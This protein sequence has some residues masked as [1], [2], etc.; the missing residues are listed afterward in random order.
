MDKIFGLPAHPL[1]VHLPVVLV[2]LVA[3]GAILLAVKKS[4]RGRFGRVLVVASFVSC[5]A[6]VLAKQSGEALFVR[7]NQA[8]DIARHQNFADTTLILAL[9]L[10]VAIV[11]MAVMHHRD[12]N[13]KTSKV[14]LIMSVASIAFGV[15]AM[16][17]TI[18]TGHEGAKVTWE[19]TVKG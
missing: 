9:L 8:P 1:M 6:L 7:M 19:Q 2:P 3:I 10:F 5:V 18:A 14:A 11:G 15:L 17:G 4:W 16:V 13:R 12:G